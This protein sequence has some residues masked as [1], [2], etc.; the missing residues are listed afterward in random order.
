[1]A[2]RLWVRATWAAAV[3]ALSSPATALGCSPA[4]GYVRPSNFELVQIADAIVVA[5]ATGVK[6]EA[7]EDYFDRKV[8]FRIAQTLKG[9]GPGEQPPSEIEVSSLALG[10]TRPSDAR[11]I[12][13]PHPEAYMGACNRMTMAKGAAYILFL[14]KT[15]KGYAPLGYPFSRVNEDYAGEDSPWM[16]TILTYLRLQNSEAPMAQVT[17]LERMRADILAKTTPTRD[18]QA[19]AIDIEMHLGSPSPWKP[20]EFLLTAYDDLRA[21]RPPRYK[22]RTPAFNAE[23]SDAA[24]L[25]GL[26]IKEAGLD[27]GKTPP[28]PSRDPR[29]TALLEMMIK[30]DHPSAMALFDTLAAPGAP[31]EDLAMAIRFYAKNGRYREAYRLIEDRTAPMVATASEAE[32]WTLLQAIEETQQDSEYH[33]GPR[34][35]RSDPD[36]AARWP[37]LALALSR[38]AVDR[39]DRDPDFHD[40]LTSLM[41]GDY[42]SNPE[43]T[44]MM[45]GHSN[46]ITTW[47]ARELVKPENLA[48]STGG[49]DDPLRLPM[50]IT[51]RWMGVSDSDEDVA[52]LTPAFCLGSAQRRMLFEDWGDLGSTRGAPAFLRLTAASVVD[53]ADRR[54]LTTV[55]PA[56]DK[57]YA[58]ENG[59]S[60]LKAD[61]AMRKLAQGQPITTKDIK[62]LKPVACPGPAASPR[63]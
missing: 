7:K 49:P 54:I 16:R 45:S 43:V 47:A 11:E 40:S 61:A 59:E 9:Q 4:P 23:Q 24:A 22:P 17:T 27:G 51:L 3:L 8:V 50:R 5:T 63:K 15:S 55:I 26:I 33:E 13:A 19:R 48:A 46:D 37:H 58:A 30:G 62:P 12:L 18:E 28:L 14:Q 53:D 21:G 39:F 36:I 6:D 29:L 2:W 38:T 41:A 31:A 32:A 44:L 34:R 1:M 52:A 56:W 25:S 60:W 10:R 42:R 20:T 57:R 35:W